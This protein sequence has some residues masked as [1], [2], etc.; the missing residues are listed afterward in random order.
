MNIITKLIDFYNL[1]VHSLDTCRL[2]PCNHYNEEHE[3]YSYCSERFVTAE[4]IDEIIEDF[5]NY[6]IPNEFKPDMPKNKFDILNL[7]IEQK[8]EKVKELSSKIISMEFDHNYEKFIRTDLVPV[9]ENKWKYYLLSNSPVCY[10]N[11]TE[12]YRKQN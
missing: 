9:D 8:L 10:I 6:E 5:Y 12:W 2:N 11:H 4:Q 7:P 1:Q 3:K